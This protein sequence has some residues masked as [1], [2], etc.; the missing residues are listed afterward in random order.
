MK[1]ARPVMRVDAVHL[2]RGNQLLLDFGGCDYLRMAQSPK[3]KRAL[4]HSIQRQGWNTAAS[5]L[6]TGNHPLYRR[7]ELKLAR[8]FGSEDAV[9]L[10]TGYLAP[11]VAAQ[12]LAGSFTHAF[13]DEAAH[14]CLQDA[15]AFLRCRVW[16]FAHRDP[17]HLERLVQRAGSNARIVV[18]TDGVFGW[19][20]SVAPLPA[21]LRALPAGSKVLVDDAHAVGV[22]G[23]NGQGTLE[24]WGISRRRVIQTVTL[25]KALGLYGGLVLCSQALREGIVQHA[26]AFGG[27]TPLPLPFVAALET[28]MEELRQRLPLRQTAMHHAER[29]RAALRKAGWQ[30]HDSPTPIVTLFPAHVQQARQLCRVLER[31]GIHP[32]WTCYPGHPAGYFRFVLTPYHKPGHVNRL[33][34]ALLQIP[35]TPGQSTLREP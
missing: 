2:R 22:L 31:V 11:V 8:F 19:S 21:Y 29:L 32:P 23:T 3:V 17:Q 30:V 4:L 6:T 25:S 33:L 34:E 10:P 15:A 35:V 7:A 9:L 26:A 13:L 12:A 14:V 1:E 18:L 5:R 20:G 16:T 28:A 24:W 27:G